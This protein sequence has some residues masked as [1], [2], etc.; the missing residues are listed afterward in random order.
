MS[1]L[2][3]NMGCCQ[4]CIFGKI[5]YF[6]PTGLTPTPEVGTPKKRKCSFCIL[7]YSGQLIFFH[8]KVGIGK[9]NF[10]KFYKNVGFGGPSPSWDKIPT[11]PK[12]LFQ[13]YLLVNS[14]KCIFVNIQSSERS[15][16]APC[17]WSCF[18]TETSP[19][20]IQIGTGYE[21]QR[22]KRYI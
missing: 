15:F 20:K 7:G 11:F 12:I 22:I 8:A 5:W 3:F 2:Y 14:E 18:Y 10:G 17:C 6:V 16:G 9:F 21:I 19:F 13:K 1:V 4:V